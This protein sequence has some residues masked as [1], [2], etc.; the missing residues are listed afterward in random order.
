MKIM[1]QAF[2][3]AAKKDPALKQAV[4]VSM[5]MAERQKK[6]AEKLIKLQKEAKDRRRK[7]AQG[8][9]QSAPPPDRPSQPVKTDDRHPHDIQKEKNR[10]AGV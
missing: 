10:A 7:R 2:L 3:K 1:Q 8:V 5:A 4:T 6:R 9:Q